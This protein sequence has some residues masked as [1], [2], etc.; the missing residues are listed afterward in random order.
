MNPKQFV[1]SSFNAFSLS[2]YI[3]F[4]FFVFLYISYLKFSKKFIK[5]FWSSSYSNFIVGILGNLSFHSSA[6]YK[7]FLV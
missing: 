6:Y 1:F 4:N 5:G 3:Y 2:I 7:K